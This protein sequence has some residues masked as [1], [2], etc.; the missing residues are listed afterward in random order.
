M[1]FGRH[2]VGDRKLSRISGRSVYRAPA[3][4]LGSAV[5]HGRLESRAS[6]ATCRGSRREILRRL[7][8]EY[9]LG[10]LVRVVVDNCGANLEPSP[11]SRCLLLGK[12][13]L[14]LCFLV[15]NVAGF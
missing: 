14:V 11:Q 4:R 9:E 15:R 8:T 3:A 1:V 7:N 2:A 6:V 5:S 12:S 13:G 10:L